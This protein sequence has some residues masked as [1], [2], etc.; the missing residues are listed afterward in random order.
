[1]TLSAT[2]FLRRFCLHI[3][4][5]G[6]RKIRHYGILSSRKKKNLKELQIKMG[7]VEQPQDA[8]IYKK[9]KL[10]KTLL[11][12][13]KLRKKAEYYFGVPAGVWKN[14]Y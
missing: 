4:P 13:V 5:K 6:F 14:I 2:E 12:T 8:I 7:V 9:Q 10:Q 3:L 11:K 1:M